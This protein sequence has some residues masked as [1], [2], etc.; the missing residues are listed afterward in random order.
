VSDG[1]KALPAMTDPR[2]D[3]RLAKFGKVVKG[4]P[5]RVEATLVPR[6]PSAPPKPA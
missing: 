1:P 5:G 6:R 4:T 3:P 2:L